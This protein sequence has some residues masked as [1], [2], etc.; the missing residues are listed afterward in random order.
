MRSGLSGARARSQADK[1]AADG[2][3]VRVSARMLGSEPG[4]LVCT[5]RV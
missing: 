1:G 5:V 2:G 4:T 3:V